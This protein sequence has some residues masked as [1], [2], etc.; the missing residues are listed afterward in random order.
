MLLILINK[1]GH[2]LI[3]IK[4]FKNFNNKISPTG[5][6]ETLEIAKSGTHIKSVYNIC[7]NTLKVGLIFIVDITCVSLIS[8]MLCS[9]V[10]FIFPKESKERDPS[11][12]ELTC[13]IVN[14]VGVT[15]LL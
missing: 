15:F 3:I 2:I 8:L 12:R 7:I 6:Q 11:G 14:I 9:F 4:C 5:L 13:F 10:F 1:V